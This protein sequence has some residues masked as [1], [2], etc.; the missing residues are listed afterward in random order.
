MPYGQRQ[1]KTIKSKSLIMTLIDSH[2]RLRRFRRGHTHGGKF[3][4]AMQWLWNN[5]IS[6]KL[7]NKFEMSFQIS[8]KA[9]YYH[10]HFMQNN[11][12]LAHVRA[13]VSTLAVGQGAFSAGRCGQLGHHPGQG[14][15][16]RFQFFVLRFQFL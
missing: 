5:I 1:T 6:R 14:A 12:R 16:L 3:C 9:Y 7:T 13:H 2:M 15:I 4:N 8:H 10:K 11:P